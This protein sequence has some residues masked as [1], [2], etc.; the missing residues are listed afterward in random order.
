MS[1]AN[2][3]MSIHDV[4]VSIRFFES[5]IVLSISEL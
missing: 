5:I 4:L 1:I 3:S 2:D